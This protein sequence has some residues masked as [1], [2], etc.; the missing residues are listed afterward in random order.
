MAW[1]NTI[2]GALSTCVGMGLITTILLRYKS[3]ER[4]WYARGWYSCERAYF[5]DGP[6]AEAD[7][8]SEAVDPPS[9]EAVPPPTE[10]PPAETPPPAGPRDRPST[11]PRPAP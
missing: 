10:T 9:V 6:P 3:K 7:P 8:P 1:F 5:P 11:G 2:F 4:E